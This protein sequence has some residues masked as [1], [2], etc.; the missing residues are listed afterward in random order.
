MI[1]GRTG[2]HQVRPRVGTAKVLGLNVVNREIY[3]FLAA[4]LA[5]KLVATEDLS[6]A[7]ADLYM[8]T[9]NHTLQS[10]N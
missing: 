10:Y 5:G 7:Q 2:S 8:R 4:I 6:S 3:C 9:M 1:A